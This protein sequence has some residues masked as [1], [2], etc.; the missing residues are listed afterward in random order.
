[1]P[2]VRIDPI[3][4]GFYSAVHNNFHVPPFL[5]TTN[6]YATKTAAVRPPEP[7]AYRHSRVFGYPAL[8]IVVIAGCPFLKRNW[9]RGEPSTSARGKRSG[10]ARSQ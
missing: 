1:V 8:V 10:P 5:P 6:L 4:A 3:D 7:L 9:T 2:E